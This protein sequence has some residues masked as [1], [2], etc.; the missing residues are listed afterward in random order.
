MY[1]LDYSLLKTE[2]SI[3]F[4]CFLEIEEAVK[5]L[6]DISKY[7]ELVDLTEE[8]KIKAEKD[9]SNSIYIGSN[10]LCTPYNW[11]RF[12]VVYFWKSTME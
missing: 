7:N 9:L 10:W 2:E 12:K 8:F 5:N 6:T 1:Y 3:Y 4:Y 11:I